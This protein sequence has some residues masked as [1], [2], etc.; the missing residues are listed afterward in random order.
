LHYLWTNRTL[1]EKIN[2]FKLQEPVPEDDLSVTVFASSTDIFLFY[3]QALTN[4][5]KLSRK[6]PFLDL[7]TIFGKWLRVYANEVL[8]SKLPKQ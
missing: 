1:E 4:C 3:K 2:G 8:L 6:K 7:C 5:A